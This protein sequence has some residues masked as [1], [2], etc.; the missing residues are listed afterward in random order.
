M[1]IAIGW[2]L[3]V[4][5][6]VIVVRTWVRRRAR[7]RPRDGREERSFS[8]PSGSFRLEMPKIS[9]VIRRRRRGTPTD[10]V[11]A[12][13]AALDD[14]AVHDPARARRESESP[15]EHATRAGIPEL[16]SLQADYALARYGGRHLTDAENRRG[17][18][19]WRRLRARLRRV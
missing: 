15:H 16:G 14:L 13:L 9:G 5:L 18:G 7:A 19:R 17:V 10:A 12:Y 2:A 3:V 11:S 8:I 6:I 4:L 1:T